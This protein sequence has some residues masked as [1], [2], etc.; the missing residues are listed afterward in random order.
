M[1]V[2]IRSREG[3]ERVSIPEGTASSATAT[4]AT[5]QSLIESQ[6]GVPVSS[7]TLS[8]DPKLLLLFSSSSSP[9]VKAQVS[10]LS[11]PSAPLS[12]LGLSHGSLLY[13]SSSQ[14]R[15]SAPPPPPRS[16]FAPAGSF[17]RNKMTIDDLIARQIRI[18]RQVIN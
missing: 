3:L 11:D 1:I 16:A 7:Q 15:L 14:P 4:V 5:L 13:L 8:L 9:E 12:S 6:L 10:T 18:T 2:R 17:G